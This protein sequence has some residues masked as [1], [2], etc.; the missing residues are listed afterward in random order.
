[1]ARSRRA[2]F[3]A[4]VADVIDDA[5]RT[6]ATRAHVQTMIVDDARCSVSAYIATMSWS[7]WL[8]RL[9]LVVWELPQN[10]LGA[11]RVGFDLALGRVKRVRIERERVLVELERG[12][13]VS[14]GLFV[15]WTSK[16]NP[17]VPVGIENVDHEFGHSIQ[18]RWLGPLYL[19]IIGVP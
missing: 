9:A 19:P 8:R 10:L 16:D 7:P 1:A 15:L 11:G 12:S 14:L 2:D 3:R 13:A 6:I 4:Y 18:S 5:G 17:Y